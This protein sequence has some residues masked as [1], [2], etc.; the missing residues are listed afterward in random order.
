[1]EFVIYGRDR[2]KFIFLGMHKDE[3]PPKLLEKILRAFD[4]N[5]DGK[6]AFYTED[7]GIDSNNIYDFFH[8]GMLK[9]PFPNYLS[10]LYNLASKEG[11][12]GTIDL[13]SLGV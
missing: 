13:A 7:Y 4:K 3:F 2:V 1:M 9:N 5:L 6:I 12:R 8:G 11:L 10:D